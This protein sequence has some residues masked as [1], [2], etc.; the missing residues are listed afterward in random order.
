MGVARRYGGPRGQV[1]HGQASVVACYASARGHALVDRRLSLP[2]DR[3]SPA[4]QERWGRGGIPAATVFPTR[5]ARAWGLLAAVHARGTRPLRWVTGAEHCGTTPVLLDQSAAAGSAYCMDG[6]HTVRG[7]PDRPPTAVPAATGRQGHPHPRVRLAPGTPTAQ[8]V[9][10]LAAQ[11]PPAA[12]PVAQLQDGS[13]GPSACPGRGARAGAGRD[14]R[15]GPD[16]WVVFRRALDAPR[17]RKVYRCNAAADTTP[18][19]LVWLVGR[20]WPSA[21]A[22]T[23]GKEELGRDHDEGRGGRGRHH[24][25]TLTLLAQHFLMRL[26]CRLGGAGPGADAPAGTAAVARDA[27]GATPRRPRAAR[28]QPGGPAPHLCRRTRPSPAA[29]APAPPL[30]RY[31]L[32][33]LTL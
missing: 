7:W 21:Q 32:Q 29:A 3:L 28:L 20:R 33:Q 5:T 12:W 10:A 18:A 15:P 31:L 24:H 8:R 1:A 16:G 30:P 23:A 17:E 6:P 27:P 25:T 4:D 22:I 9:D 13:K 11:R 26:R 2:A 19:T 14:S